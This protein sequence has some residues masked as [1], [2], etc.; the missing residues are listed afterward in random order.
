MDPSYEQVMREYK[1]HIIITK[2]NIAINRF[3]TYEFL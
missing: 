3:R 2:Y 1:D